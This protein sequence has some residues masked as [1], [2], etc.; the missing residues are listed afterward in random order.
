MFGVPVLASKYIGALDFIEENKNG[1]IFDPLDKLE[2]INILNIPAI[3]N[4]GKKS[5]ML[6]DFYQNVKVFDE[7]KF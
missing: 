6:K 3:E 4:K 5:L 7:F 2:F 1:H